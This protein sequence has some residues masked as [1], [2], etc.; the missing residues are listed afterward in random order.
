MDRAFSQRAR[1]AGLAR[2][3]R[4]TGISLAGA[5]GLSAVFAGVAATSSHAKRAVRTTRI[6]AS[7]TGSTATPTL[8]PAQPP[9]A[10]ETPA[11]P[12]PPAAAPTPSTSPPVAVTGGS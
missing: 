8:P 7:V 2:L 10:A 6:R 11:A 5:L 12:T 4:L 3:R 9:S 1:D